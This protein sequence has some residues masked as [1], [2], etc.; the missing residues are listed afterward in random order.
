M[1]INAWTVLLLFLVLYFVFQ[2]R[3]DVLRYYRLVADRQKMEKSIN[4]ILVNNQDLKK[5][6]S[7]LNDSALIESLARERLNLIKKG[8]TA[9]KVCRLKPDRM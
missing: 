7:A 3:E 4:E 5:R 1:K 6:I 2:I 9:Y 8:E